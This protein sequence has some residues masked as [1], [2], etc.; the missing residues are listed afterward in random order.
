M[1]SHR[2]LMVVRRPLVPRLARLGC[3]RP[4]CRPARPGTCLVAN[5]KSTLSR[6]L[7]TFKSGE[8]VDLDMGDYPNPEYDRKND[9]NRPEHSLDFIKL[10]NKL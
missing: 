2:E 4:A 7:D 5:S 8:K 3:F 6:F 10:I 1:S 9:L